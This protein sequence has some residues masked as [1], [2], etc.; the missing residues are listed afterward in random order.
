MSE[1]YVECLVKPEAPLLPRFLRIVLIMLTVV[2]GFLTL[3]GIGMALLVAIL[4]GVGAYFAHLNADVE[5]EYLYFYREISVDKIMAQTRRKR[6]ATFEVERMEILAPLKS[7]RLDNYKNRTCKEI[8]FS[9]RREEQPDRRY[10][11]Y[12]EGNQK[13][14]LSPSEEML[15]AIR[16]VAP[17]KVF[18]D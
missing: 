12:Y 13:I 16:N 9:V 15:K 7:Y 1:T 8:D 2:F 17:R 10:V 5:Y 3:L 18:T 6:V 11:M 4:A 14:I